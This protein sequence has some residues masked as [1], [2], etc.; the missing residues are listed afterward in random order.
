M[1]SLASELFVSS[2][3]GCDVDGKDA[4]LCDGI[5]GGGGGG[6]DKAEEEEEEEANDDVDDSGKEWCEL[7]VDLK[8]L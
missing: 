6:D 8:M 4:L 1:N 3:K 2:G 7:L 5:A